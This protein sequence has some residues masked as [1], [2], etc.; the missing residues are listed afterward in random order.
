M[1]PRK[2]NRHLPPCV[3]LKHGAYYLVKGGVWKPLGRDLPGALAA[4]ARSHAPQGG[5]DPF[6]DSAVGAITLKVSA[7]TKRQYKLCAKTLKYLLGNFSSP[8]Q[9]KHRDAQTVKR[10][11]AHV[12][13]MA[14][15]VIS[16]GKLIFSYA[17]ENELIDAN[18][19]LGVKRFKENKRKR[20]L[21]QSEYDAIYG[22][23][24]NR[25]QVIMDLLYL[26]GQRVSDVLNI[27]RANLTDEGIY[28][29]Q[30][31]TEARLIVR[32]SPDL[33]SVVERAKGLGG[34]V[35]ALTLLYNHH[36]K[37]MNYK[38][39]LAQWTRTCVSAGVK[40]ATM[41]DIRAMAATDADRQSK[42]ATAL[43]GHTSKAMTVRYLRDK[44]VPVVD[45]PSFRQQLDVRQKP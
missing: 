12:P 15:Q 39:V 34:N 11:L 38:T 21:S 8:T 41:R 45:G 4:Y 30:A 9:V 32:W 2:K 3:H 23:A 13:N 24:D 10:E 6:I 1:R 29:E 5:I 36:G 40:D 18:P 16:V 25:L 35:R 33:R 20:L 7:G 26:T 37:P 44:Q 28:F 22:K 17:V 42:D 43:L 19:F 27:R 14:N 31:K